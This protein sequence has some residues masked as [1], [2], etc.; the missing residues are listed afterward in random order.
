MVKETPLQ[1]ISGLIREFIT[2]ITYFFSK[3]I[4]KI[5]FAM[6]P[7]A[8]AIVFFLENKPKEEKYSN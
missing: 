7:I 6:L 8:F 3:H 4:D 2:L 1:Y 5:F